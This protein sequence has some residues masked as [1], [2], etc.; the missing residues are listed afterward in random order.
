MYWQYWH[1]QWIPLGCS[2]HHC[3]QH[4]ACFD[5]INIPWILQNL[6]FLHISFWQ[7][8]FLNISND[9]HKSWPKA[10]LH[11]SLFDLVN[12][13]IFA[14]SC[15]GWHNYSLCKLLFQFHRQL[16]LKFHWVKTCLYLAHIDSVH[17]TNYTEISTIYCYH[18]CP[19]K[20]PYSWG[21][22]QGV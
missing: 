1:I 17:I 5:C 6:L 19:C 4:A 8:K 10:H 14:D 15:A 13:L 2:L 7:E 16:A 3:M 12:P 20:S 22:S 21:S 9:W 11:I 18:V